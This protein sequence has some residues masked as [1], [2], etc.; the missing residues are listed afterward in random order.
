MKPFF[1]D[2]FSLIAENS[3]IYTYR[4]KNSR[5]TMKVLNPGDDALDYQIMSKVVGAP[6]I[7]GKSDKY[8]VL[9]YELKRLTNQIKLILEDN[10][11]DNVSPVMHLIDKSKLKKMEDVASELSLEKNKL[12]KDFIGV[13]FGS[14]Y[15]KNLQET[16]I[17]LSIE[18]NSISLDK[19]KKFLSDESFDL[20]KSIRE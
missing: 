13:T 17:R 12:I 2:Y 10:D 7:E 14:N 19:I 4:D 18:D 6:K 3:G 8:S 15:D 1:T 20:I 11:I 16:I 5:T 9:T